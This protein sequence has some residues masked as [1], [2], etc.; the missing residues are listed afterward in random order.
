MLQDNATDTDAAHAAILQTARARRAA[1][2]CD[3]L[4][5]LRPPR[6]PIRG[7][8]RIAF[9]LAAGMLGLALYT[10]GL[11]LL[12]ATGVMTPAMLVV[13]GAAAIS[14]IVGLGFSALCSAVLLHLVDSPVTAVQIMLLSSIGIQVLCVGT[15][16]RA[17]D[18]PALAPLLAGGAMG[19]PG[20][21]WL[22]FHLSRQQYAH[23]L[24]LLLVAYGVWTL[25]RRAQIVWQST[26][27]TAVL[28]GV[29]G[30]I[31]GGLAALPAPFVS[32][33]CSLQ[34]WD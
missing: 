26:W 19:L 11:A 13:L 25:L 8:A 22:L 15:L 17:V 18:G 6:L 5:K 27:W 28:A 3:S 30:G 14:S 24:G 29:L 2:V 16:R 7:G 20:G 32:I 4:P 9:M 33:W 34:G 12:G 10:H 23:V 1:A 21:L 31:T